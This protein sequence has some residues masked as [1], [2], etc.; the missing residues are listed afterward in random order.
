MFRLNLQRNDNAPLTNELDSA[1]CKAATGIG[2]FASL[3][4][5]M[6]QHASEMEA[7]LNAL[8]DAFDDAMVLN[9]LPV[10]AGLRARVG[11][12]L[13]ERAQQRAASLL[14]AS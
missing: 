14:K 13:R 5:P 2:D 11:H 4:L 8:L 3:Y 10:P 7:R 1:L 6:Y 12:M 9:A